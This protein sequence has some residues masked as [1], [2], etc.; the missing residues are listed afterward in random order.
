MLNENRELRSELIN[1]EQLLQ[2]K[3]HDH[4]KAENLLQEQLLETEKLKKAI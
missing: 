4:H 3:E 2:N 1:T